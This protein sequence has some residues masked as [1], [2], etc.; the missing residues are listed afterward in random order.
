MV[1]VKVLMKEETSLTKW[2]PSQKTNKNINQIILICEMING[3]NW[4]ISL[5]FLTLILAKQLWL[6]DIV[7]PLKGNCLLGF[8]FSVI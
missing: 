2:Y 7:N 6:S 1:E 5:Y 8:K 4:H 3:F